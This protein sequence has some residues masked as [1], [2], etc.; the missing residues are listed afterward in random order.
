[1]VIA[2]PRWFRRRKYGGWGVAPRTWQGIVYI[3][4]VMIPFTIFQ[5]LPYWNT[6]TRLIVTGV[7]IL[8][9]VIDMFDV[10]IR[11]KKDEREK[12]HE[13]LAERNA[14]WIMMMVLVM[15]ILY[16]VITSALS[17]TI[18]VDWFI[19]IALFAGLIVKTISNIVLDRKN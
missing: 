5:A 7:W 19:L 13:A 12:I 17:Q 2:Q 14:L 15:G 6:Q 3:I 4:V 1:M 11:L 10:M 9:L 8:F 18:K 16:Q